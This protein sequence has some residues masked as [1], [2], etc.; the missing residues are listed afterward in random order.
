M[1][2]AVVEKAVTELP[3]VGDAASFKVCVGAVEVWRDGR[4][5]GGKRG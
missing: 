1:E 4:D 5:H 3:V 2:F